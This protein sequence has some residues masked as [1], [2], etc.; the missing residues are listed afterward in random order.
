MTSLIFHLFVWFCH[1][2][3]KGETVRTYVEHVMNICNL[4][5]ANSLTKHTLLIIR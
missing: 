3:P 4:K 1:G 5:L 2:L